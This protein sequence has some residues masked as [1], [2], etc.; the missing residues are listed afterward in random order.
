MRRI[1]D[2]NVV[3]P[4]A[5]A[6]SHRDYQRGLGW[7]VGDVLIAD[8]GAASFRSRTVLITYTADGRTIAVSLDGAA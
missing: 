6:R 2:D 8:D 5:S 3:T 7:D 4:E 1:D